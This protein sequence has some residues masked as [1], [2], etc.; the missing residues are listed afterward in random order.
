LGPHLELGLIGAAAE[1][2]RGFAGNE[3]SAEEPLIALLDVV[4][5]GIGDW[6]VGDCLTSALRK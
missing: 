6:S 1:L 3:A 5:V 2:G 4:G